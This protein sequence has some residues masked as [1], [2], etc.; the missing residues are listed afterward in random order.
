MEALQQASP[1]IMKPPSFDAS[2]RNLHL[3]GDENGIA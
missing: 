3:L 1:D 2:T